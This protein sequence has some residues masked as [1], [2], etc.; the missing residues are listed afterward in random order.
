MRRRIAHV[1]TRLDLGGAQQNTLF[2]AAHHD[3]LLFEVIVIAGPGGLLDEEA[4]GLPDTAIV[5]E[6]RL[7][8]P[9][10]PFRDTIALTALAGIL[11]GRRIDL[12][13]THSSKAGMLG[14]WAARLA[15]V[16]RV[17]HTVHGWSFNDEQAP[18]RRHFYQ[19]LERMTASLTDRIIVVS[20]ADRRRGIAA[21]IGNFDRYRL[22]RSGIDPEAYAEP[23][24]PREEV[25]RALGFDPDH[26][27]VG[28]L[29]CLKPQKAP[30]DFVDAA[31]A[32]HARD[33]RARFF[34]AGDGEMRSAV[35]ARIAERGLGGVVRLLGWRRDVADLLHAMDVF[36]LASRFEGLPRAEL[37]AMAAGLPIVATGVDGTPEAVR[38]G[39]NGFLVPAG[40]PELLAERLTRLSA[41]E[42]LRRRFGERGRALLSE[43]FNIR[44]MVPALDAIYAELLGI[45]VRSH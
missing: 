13:H 42:P 36:L 37:Q 30:L 41:S 8:H 25:R 22:V 43:E 34:I 2:S 29:A 40:R 45:Q 18:A 38:E 26:L 21:G 1:I 10:S 5:F 31:A 28:T 16:P 7:R 3:R 27:V 20:E 32:T 9:I 15:G 23:R 19:V 11:R 44:R 4:R 24:V 39:E 33:P 35:E 12:V 14:R 6:P 17:V